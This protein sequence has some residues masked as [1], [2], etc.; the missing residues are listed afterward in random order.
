MRA[1]F[2]ARALVGTAAAAFLVAASAGATELNVPADYGTI[3]EAIEASEWGDTI[4][5]APGTYKESLIFSDAKGDGVIL[6]STEG[7]SATTI[8]YGETAN[9][10]EAVITLQRCSNSTQIVGFTVDG[11]GVARRGLLVNSD[12]KPVLS[13]LVVTNS[14]YGIASHRG[15]FPYIEKTR[16]HGTATAGLFVQGGSADVRDCA[17]VDSQKFGI[18]VR[19]TLDPMRLRG[20][21][22]TN[23]GQVGLQATE[24]EFTV[25]NGLFANNGDSGMILQDVS[26][27]MRNLTVENHPNVGLV[28]EACWGVLEDCIIRNNEY[29][30]VV[31]VEGSPEIYNC[32][33][34][35]NASYHIGIEGDSDPIVGGSLELANQFLGN[36][37][38]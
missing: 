31:S 33:F 9:V 23:N 19:G 5:V 36:A 34:E 12:S 27:E 28:M 11:R 2:R 15:S 13:E 24:G 29:G 35:N 3:Q 30:I 22:V 17:F 8:A 25:E 26:P 21:T 20:I 14:E 7:A 10:N 4:L 37:S 18:Y 32:D 1:T 6:R 16:V 38:Y